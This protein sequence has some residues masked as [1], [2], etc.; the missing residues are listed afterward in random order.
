[1]GRKWS[2]GKLVAVSRCRSP[3]YVFS[4][5]LKLMTKVKVFGEVSYCSDWMSLLVTIVAVWL[6]AREK[7]VA[8][9]RDKLQFKI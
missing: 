5:S 3:T 2:K 4:L 8:A 7:L 9:L 6:V 1:M